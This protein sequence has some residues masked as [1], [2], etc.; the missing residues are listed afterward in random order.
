[1]NIGVLIKKS[2]EAKGLTQKE[3]A[4]SVKMDQS[5]YSKIEKGKTD[6]TTSTLQKISKSLGMSL[7]ELVS[8]DDI[9][10]DTNSFDKTLLEKV[11]LIEEL[12]ENEQKS[13]FNIIDG[14]ISKKRLRDTLKKALT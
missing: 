11:K 6:P 8:A 3:V 7:S 9:F 13:I 14:L 4:S 10:S 1:M 12:D 5:Q 2:R